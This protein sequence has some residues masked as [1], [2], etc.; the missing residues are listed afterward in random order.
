MLIDSTLREGAQQYGTY[1]DTGA[2]CSILHG[3][4]EL[5]VEEIEM[6]W[7]GQEGL[8]EV[9]AWARRHATA[10]T[11]G[12]WAPCRE[13]DILR[14]RKYT[15]DILSIGIP[16]SE[17]HISRRL[18]RDRDSLPALAASGVRAALEAGHPA[19]SLGL[20]DA[21]RADRA[22]AL[23]VARAA[24]EAGASRIRLSDTRG[25]LAPL[26]VA[27]LVGFFREK[28]DTALAVHCHDD[29]GMATANAA[30]ALNEGADYADAALL[31]TGERSGIA[32]TEELAAYLSLV[33][34]R[35]SY[36]LHGI[37]E[38]C[39]LFAR[40]AGLALPRNKAVAG[41]DIFACESGLHAQ[42][43]EV[44]DPYDPVETG[45]QRRVGVGAKSGNAAVRRELE[46][47]G[48]HCPESAFPRLVAAV[49]AEARLLER[50]LTEKE[51]GDAVSSVVSRHEVSTSG[52]NG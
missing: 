45:G 37:G 32:A 33:S 31:G 24:L 34:G 11:L 44:F 8:E 22:F 39:G 23:E 16:V 9:F 41:R 52:S 3:L 18:G 40:E 25:Q 7:P 6:G 15:P 20:E 26:D 28:L 10:T 50:P 27:R 46:R 29:F 38:L 17:E 14:A 12:L 36:G 47:L 49:R 13:R 42:A 4:L 48:L 43:P 19:V 5:G 1:L 51:L 2:R 35:R 21:S 30:T